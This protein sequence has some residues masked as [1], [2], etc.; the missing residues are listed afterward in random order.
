MAIDRGELLFVK[1]TISINSVIAEAA[2]VCCWHLLGYISDGKRV[3]TAVVWN[4]SSGNY[5][6]CF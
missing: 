3:E 5:L 2:H 1:C 4:E 6:Q